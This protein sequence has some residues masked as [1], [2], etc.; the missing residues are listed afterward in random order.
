[1]ALYE[2][3]LPIVHFSS[4]HG[5]DPLL[6]ILTSSLQQLTY[7]PSAFTVSPSNVLARPTR[8]IN[9]LPL[10]ERPTIEL[11]SPISST[12]FS[13]KEL[14][15]LCLED[16]SGGSSKR[17]RLLSEGS[18][19]GKSAYSKS[20]KSGAD[21]YSFAGKYRTCFYRSDS[22]D[23]CNIISSG[24]PFVNTDEVLIAGAMHLAL[25]EDDT[26]VTCQKKIQ[27]EKAL[28]TYLS[29]NV[30]Y[31][32]STFEPVC[33]YA[34]EH[35]QSKQSIPNS[36]GEYVDS[37]ALE[38]EVQYIH[39]KQ[40]RNLSDSCSKTEIATCCSQHAINNYVG[41]YCAS[42]AC[43]FSLDEC[44]SGRQHSRLSS[45]Q[46]KSGKGS[47]GSLFY[48]KSGKGEKSNKSGKA[49]YVYTCPW[50]GE[51]LYLHLTLI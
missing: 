35:A 25:L 37:T 29:D 32:D 51:L 23:R 21:C 36:G 39:K 26:E 2:T 20:G 6:Q 43:S 33:V 27:V 44:G 40:Q 7:F 31:S 50:Y 19:S 16:G 41:E 13:R 22:L 12:P 17:Y 38:I 28:L 1:M 9:Y 46:S 24:K 8:Q 5:T 18:K 47:K 48:G 34:Y 11:V 42:L 3:A 14:E 10:N 30:G 4:Q 15:G 49:D 45:G